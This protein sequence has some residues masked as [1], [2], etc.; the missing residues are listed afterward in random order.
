MESTVI[1]RL[2]DSKSTSGGV[3]CILGTRTVVPIS[4]VSNKHTA[5]VELNLK[6]ISLDAGLHMEGI[7]ALSLWDLVI[8][9]FLPS[10][11]RNL[12]LTLHSNQRATMSNVLS[13]ID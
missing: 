8:E 3:L 7:T 6:M 5:I 9:V 13:N 4:W 1:A 2:S 10:A 12:P 11:R